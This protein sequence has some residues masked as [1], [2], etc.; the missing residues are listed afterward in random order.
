MSRPFIACLF[1]FVI[2]SLPVFSENEVFHWHTRTG[3]SLYVTDKSGLDCKV[4]PAET[5]QTG[6]LFAIG[7]YAAVN[8][9]VGMFFVQ[10]SDAAGGF[11]FR[12]FQDLLVRTDLQGRLP[13]HGGENSFYLGLSVGPELHYA[14]YLFTRI[15]FFYLAVF[16]EPFF[17]IVFS[18]K[19]QITVRLSTPVRFQFRTD[20]EFSMSAGLGITFLFRPLYL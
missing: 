12:G 18:E 2:S 11:A 15:Q 10:S 7:D 3:F 8:T 6:F 9:T 13:L 14:H 17:D 5:V 19:Q 20:T 4:Q 1:F 16:G